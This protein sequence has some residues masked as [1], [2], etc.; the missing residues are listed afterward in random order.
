MPR[1]WSIPLTDA[2]I[3]EMKSKFRAM[4]TYKPGGHIYSKDFVKFCEAI[5]YPRTQKQ[6]M[7]YKDLL[8]KTYGG[9]YTMDLFVEAAK[10]IHSSSEV[11]RFRAEQYDLDGNGYISAEEFVELMEF[12]TIHDP[13]LPKTNFEQFVKQADTDKDGKVSIDE[14]AKWIEANT[15]A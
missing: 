11:A 15:N 1:D 2:E 10:R 13:S 4:P 8:D 7:A 6:L 9:I 14:C 3:E 12:M 5:G